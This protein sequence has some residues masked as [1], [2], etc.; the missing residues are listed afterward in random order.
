[1][2]KDTKVLDVH[3]HVSAPNAARNWIMGGF[4]SGYVGPSPLRS[5]GGGGGG[6]GEGGGGAMGRIGGGPPNPLS[7]EAFMQSNKA[8]A[9]YMDER[10]IDVQVIG[11]RPFTMMGWMPR[12][13]LVRWCEFTNDTIKKQSEGALLQSQPPASASARGQAGAPC[14]TIAW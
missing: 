1:M 14:V 3:G 9:E 6:G 4:S 8:H 12:H 7:D 10:N 2:F 11:P 13:L 5:R